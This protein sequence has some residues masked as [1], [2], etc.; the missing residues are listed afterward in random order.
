MQ[1]R[2]K[3]FDNIRNFRDFG[4]YDGAGGR[5][6]RSGILFR[7]AQ[8]G[9]ASRADL[10]A[11]ETYRIKVQADLRRPDER[12]RH[13]HRWPVQG[14]QVLSSDKGSA[15]QAPHVRFLSEV[16]VDAPKAHGWMVEYYRDAPFKVQHVETFSAWFKA[17]GQL[18]E[19]A[20]AVV[21][22]AAGKDRTGILCALTHHVLGV[23]R[24]A[25]FAD[26]ELTNSA[27]N[28]AERLPEMA[29]MFNQHIGKDYDD[30]VYHPFVGVD[31][32]FL[33]AAM[34]S[35]VAQSGSLDTYLSDTLG[36]GATERDQLRAAL[37]D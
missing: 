29:R 4:A 7:S 30:D 37:L 5:K 15:T 33:E 21:N 22:C 26:Y 19:G 17:L 6:V 8:F 3:S 2:V 20:A 9:E 13:G 34:D 32:S 16:A 1:D 31:A 12:E 23:E 10:D 14:V 28:V 27:A 18:E 11:L 35:I 24:E 36:V 25:I